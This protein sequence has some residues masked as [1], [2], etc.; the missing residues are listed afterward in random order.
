MGAPFVNFFVL[1]QSGS[2][3]GHGVDLLGV[4]AAGQVVDGGV[5]AWALQP[6]DRSLMG[7]FRPSRMGP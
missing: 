3:N 1:G 2:D 4:A 6:R 5:Q 7:A